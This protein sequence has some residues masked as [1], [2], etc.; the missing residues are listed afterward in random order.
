[1]NG[2]SVVEKFISIN[3]ESRRAGE[4]AV[5]VRFRGCNLRCNYCDTLWAC[6]D[7]AECE[8]MS[9]QEIYEYIKSTGIK[10]VTL[11]GGEPMLQKDI[12]ELLKLLGGDRNLRIEV[13]T[14]G[15]VLL[16]EYYRT[17]PENISFTVDYKCPGSGMEK[18][19]C[20]RN[21]EE[22]RELDTVKFVVSDRNDLDCMVKIIDTYRLTE[23]CMVYVSAVFG[24][25]EPQEIVEYMTEHK[26]N[27]V[28]LQLQMHKFI[29]D[30]DKRGV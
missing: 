22:I 8:Y 6:V 26:L 19:M 7:T 20:L 10:N 15:A 11:T 1:M 13:E 16:D 4:L 30:P 17:V 14:N 3:G 28:R 23:K 2:F 12:K 5:F 21:F 24:R 25:I 18:L 29:W 27:D 9:V